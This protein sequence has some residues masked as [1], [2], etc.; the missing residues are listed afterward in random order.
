M[1]FNQTPKGRAEKEPKEDWRKSLDRRNNDCEITEFERSGQED[2]T[3]QHKT[4]QSDL[5]SPSWR[6]VYQVMRLKELEQETVVFNCGVR[7]LLIATI[8]KKGTGITE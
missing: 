8:H 1:A 2:K 6:G 5:R 3:K 7:G 4:Q